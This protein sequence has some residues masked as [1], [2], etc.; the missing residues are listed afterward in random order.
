MTRLVEFVCAPL[1][2]VSARSRRRRGS[3]A[4]EEAIER[5]RGAFADLPGPSVD[6]M[7]SEDREE[8]REIEERKFGEFPD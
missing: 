2:R 1:R 8:E 5:A 7:R 4:R 3:A 6:Q